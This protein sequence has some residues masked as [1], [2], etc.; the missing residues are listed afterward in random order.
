MNALMAILA[1]MPAGARTA[2]QKM[3]AAAIAV[4]TAATDA[5]GA[6]YSWVFAMGDALVVHPYASGTMKF[7]IRDPQD[8]DNV[9]PWLD[10][11]DGNAAVFPGVNPD[12]ASALR[13]LVKCAA[14]VLGLRPHPDDGPD[15]PEALRARGAALGLVTWA[16]HV[17]SAG[18]LTRTLAASKDAKGKPKPPTRDG[19]R[20][21]VAKGTTEAAVKR[22]DRKRKR[23]IPNARATMTV[24]QL[25]DVLQRCATDISMIDASQ[26][27]A[28]HVSALDR[29]VDI[30]AANRDVLLG[31]DV[32]SL[33]VH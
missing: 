7:G 16:D 15:T 23:T 1:S 22:G 3:L 11:M 17:A 27:T 26:F 10:N 14:V 29:D 31:R 8:S 9:E 30:L 28:D 20:K 24:T 33:P 18:E 4:D 13:Q 32:V 25:L 19:V 6:V 5:L 21:A 2:H 12:T